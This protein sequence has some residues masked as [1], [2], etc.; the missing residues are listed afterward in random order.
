MRQENGGQMFGETSDRR[1]TSF[2]PRALGCGRGF[3]PYLPVLAG[4]HHVRMKTLLFFTSLLIIIFINRAADAVVTCDLQ[5]PTVSGL[6]GLS[7]PD[8][9]FSLFKHLQRRPR[10]R[11]S[12]FDYD[13][14]A[15]FDQ[16]KMTSDFDGMKDRNAPVLLVNGVDNIVSGPF[17]YS[18]GYS[19]DQHPIGTSYSPADMIPCLSTVYVKNEYVSDLTF[20]APF[21]SQSGIQ[22]K[23]NDVI[24]I[25]PSPGAFI[26]GSL[27]LGM[28]GWLRRNR[29]L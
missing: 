16:G 28:I 5:Y 29:M 21:N 13:A 10:G 17:L 20:S 18:G 3:A 12:E 2:R 14:S 25:V 22:D 26:L 4:L 7:I 23:E 8:S 15:I 19:T 6:T 27:G 1:L 9:R 11:V 24:D